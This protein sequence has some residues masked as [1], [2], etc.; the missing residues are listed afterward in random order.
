MILGTVVQGTVVSQTATEIPMSM[1]DM[2]NYSG[3]APTTAAAAVSAP[4][5]NT[6]TRY[7]IGNATA[8]TAADAMAGGSA[9][10]PNRNLDSR[11]PGNRI[12]GLAF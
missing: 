9:K 6:N 4:A 11:I 7:V 2:M 12:P 1:A 3:P 8:V 10:I 5:A